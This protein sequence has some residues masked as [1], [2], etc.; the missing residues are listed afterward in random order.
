MITK[1]SKV[2]T[3]DDGEDEGRAT[4]L[5][6]GNVSQFVGLCYGSHRKLTHYTSGLTEQL[7]QGAGQCQPPMAGPSVAAVTKPSPGPR[8]RDKDYLLLDGQKGKDLVGAL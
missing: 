6:R 1:V 7:S 3:P 5:V 8:G 4:L 2:V